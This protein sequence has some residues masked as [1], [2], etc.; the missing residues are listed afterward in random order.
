MDKDTFTEEGRKKEGRGHGRRSK[1]NETEKVVRLRMKG[2]T[3]R[4]KELVTQG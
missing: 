3:K 2:G 1:E 4:L